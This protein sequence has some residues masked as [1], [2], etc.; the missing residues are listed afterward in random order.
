M[1]IFP[2]PPDLTSKSRRDV[3]VYYSQRSGGL[4]G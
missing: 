3:I 1:Y 2:V 4:D